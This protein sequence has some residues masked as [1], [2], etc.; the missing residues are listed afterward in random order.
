MKL[1]VERPLTPSVDMKILRIK[2]EEANGEEVLWFWERVGTLPIR[3]IGDTGAAANCPGGRLIKQID[4]EKLSPRWVRKNPSVKVQ[5]PNGANM[6]VLG[7]RN[8]SRLEREG[9]KS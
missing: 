8:R 5:G 3:I 4:E 9:S 2:I 1:T 6:E 7:N